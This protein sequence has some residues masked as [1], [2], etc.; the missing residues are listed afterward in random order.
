MKLSIYNRV[1]VLEIC[2]FNGLDCSRQPIF[3]MCPKQAKETTIKVNFKF[4]HYLMYMG[5]THTWISRRKNVP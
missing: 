2:V 4:E 3:D 1:Q 5:W